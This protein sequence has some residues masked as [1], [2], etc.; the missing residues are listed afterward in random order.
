MKHPV[1]YIGIAAFCAVVVWF[2][3]F[4]RPDEAFLVVNVG[5]PAWSGVL[6]LALGVGFFASYFFQQA[7]FAKPFLFICQHFSA[8]ASDKMALF[9]GALLSAGGVAVVTNAL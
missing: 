1:T 3:F 2:L 9:Y 4:S 8:P 7:A 5:G 6:M